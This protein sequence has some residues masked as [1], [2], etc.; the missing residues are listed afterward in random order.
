MAHYILYGARLDSDTMMAVLTTNPEE[1][2]EFISHQTGWGLFAGAA[3]GCL[4]YIGVHVWMAGRRRQYA[5]LTER[6]TG[7]RYFFVFLSYI[8]GMGN[9]SLYG[10]SISFPADCR[11]P[12]L[13]DGYS[14]FQQQYD[15]NAEN[16]RLVSSSPAKGTVILVV[17]ES[18]TRD[19]MK[20]FTPSYPSDTTPWMTSTVSQ[21]GYFL[22][23]RAYSNFPQTIPSLSM[24]LTSS[25]QYNGQDLA[26][27]VSIMD[28]A[29]MK[30]YRTYWIGNHSRSATGNTPVSVIA[31]RAQ[32]VYWTKNAPEYD[33]NIMPFLKQIPAEGANFVVIHIMGSHVQYTNRVPD[34]FMYQGQSE[35]GENGTD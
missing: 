34:D 3:A 27:S 28:I 6:K 23:S 14:P 35:G 19:H 10:N 26:D 11:C 33:E 8:N 15:R 16:I 2:S 20:A 18:E 9:D 30:G 25:N 4:A 1:A 29:R 13:S 32:Q 12:F 22:F 21:P 24:Y 17:G 31:Q 7:H 5:V